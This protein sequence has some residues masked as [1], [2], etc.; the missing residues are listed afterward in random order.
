MFRHVKQSRSLSLQIRE[1]GKVGDRTNKDF[2]TT[3]NEMASNQPEIKVNELS[4]K[5]LTLYNKISSTKK[6][7]KNF[8]VLKPM[9]FTTKKP[10]NHVRFVC[11][12]DTHNKT[13]RMELPE[14]DVLLHAGDFTQTGGQNEVKHFIDFL[15][16]VRDQFKQMIVIAGN[17]D[18]TFDVDNYDS[19]RGIASMFH[20]GKSF[21]LQA[22]K[23]SLKQKCTY[24]EDEETDVSGIKIYG[25]PWQ[26]EFGGWG[27]NL[28]RGDECLEKWN[29]IPDGVDILI[30]HGPPLGHGDRC[31]D[32]MRAGCAELLSTIQERVKPKYHIF[33]HI[34]EGYGITTDGAT[35]YINAS[36][37]NI[38]YSQVHQ[39]IIFDLPIKK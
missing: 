37:V 25:T 24:L 9:K 39:P 28:K 36:S 8:K 2:A 18:L 11:I 31:Q 38:Q 17:H 12:S 33:G 21:D 27:F 35:N 10:D 32:G 23:E 26:P 13:D 14:G 6:W 3:W 7:I 5:P 16:R 1:C 19:T 4:N 20:A 29:S 15:D 34:H 22:I 30:T